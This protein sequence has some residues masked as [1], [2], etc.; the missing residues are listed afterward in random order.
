MTF[1]GDFVCLLK[2][3]LAMMQLFLHLLILMQYVTQTEREE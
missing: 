2:H 3:L 1:S